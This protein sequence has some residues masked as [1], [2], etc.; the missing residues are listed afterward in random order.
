MQVAID[1]FLNSKMIKKKD[2]E[3]IFM[4]KVA[5]NMF[6]ISKMIKKKDKELI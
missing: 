3:P 5:I 2:K 6:V 1:M 4:Q